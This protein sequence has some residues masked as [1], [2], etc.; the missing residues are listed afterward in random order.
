MTEWILTSSVLILLVLAI[1]GIFKK[2][3][4]AKSIYAL[5]LIVLVRLLCPINFGELSFNLLSLAEEG[6]VQL[7]ERLEEHLESPAK[8]QS[9][10][11]NSSEDGRVFFY[12]EASEEPGIAYRFKILSPSELI[13]EKLQAEEE[14]ELSEATPGLLFAKI[15][16]KK[17]LPVFWGIGIAVMAVVICCVNISFGIGLGLFR[18]K[19][20]A[21]IKKGRRKQ[22]LS[23]Y[24]A[25]GIISSCLYGVFRPSIYLNREGMSEKEK[26]YCVEHEYSHYLQGDMVWSLCR[27]LCLVLHWYNPLVW[28][29]VILSKRDAELACDERTIERLGEEER[30]NYGHTL[31]ELAAAQSR[32]VQLFGVATLMASDKKEVVERVKAITTKKQTKLITGLLVA[33]LVVG[34]GFFVFTGEARGEQDNN[35][36][37][38]VVTETPVPTEE[39]KQTVAVKT[40]QTAPTPRPTIVVCKEDLTANTEAVNDFLEETEFPVEGYITDYDWVRREAESFRLYEKKD[41]GSAYTEHVY[42]PQYISSMRD[43]GDACWFYIRT[44][45]GNFGWVK[46]GEHEGMDARI[47]KLLRISEEEYEANREKRAQEVEQAI[48]K[49]IEFEPL[50]FT[51]HAFLECEEGKGWLVDLNGDGT[52]EQL[53]FDGDSVFVDGKI[54]IHYPKTLFLWLLDIDTT[55]GMYELLDSNG[56]LFIYED[57][58]FREVKG[59]REIYF[60]ES[61]SGNNQV[62]S[63]YLGTLSE[64]TRIDEHT[65]TFEDCFFMTATFYANAQYVLDENHNLQMVPQVYDITCYD[66]INN[67][68]WANYYDNWVKAFKLYKEPD[69]SAKYE[70]VYDLSGITLRK[71]DCVEWVYVERE[72]GLAGW[73][74]FGSEQKDYYFVS[75]V[76]D[77]RKYERVL[78]RLYEQKN[79]AG[80]YTEAVYVPTLIKS[81]REDTRETDWCYVTLRTGEEGWIPCNAEDLDD[82]YRGLVNEQGTVD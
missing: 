1:R 36:K 27:V 38:P 74:Y 80:A 42:Y 43:S 77:A 18:K 46:Y 31:V 15:D 4:K 51:D 8:G 61:E 56:N 23:V 53:S 9:E 5:W 57:G 40:V 21:Y 32:S 39:A 19:Q 2:R 47:L 30:F 52:K 13:P 76:S 69:V 7:E 65:I 68:N 33:A 41:T 79:E 71:S 26:T 50:T 20:P 54:K 6:K 11:E 22:E 73:L 44:D 81:M 48:Q 25:D 29:A 72:D 34:I 60:A 3:I 17:V 24:M 64:F 12:A 67:V 78:I 59:I 28:L 45:D 55:D 58:E 16:W 35:N 14:T 66:N 62:F 70:E 49:N 37:V 82:W 75:S 10:Q 63:K